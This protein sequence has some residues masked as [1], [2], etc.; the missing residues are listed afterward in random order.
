MY[1]AFLAMPPLATCRNVDV[2][3]ILQLETKLPHSNSQGRV[4]LSQDLIRVSQYILC[5]APVSCG[6]TSL[7]HGYSFP[8]TSAMETPFIG[9]PHLQVANHPDQIYQLMHYVSECDHLINAMFATA[10]SWPPKPSMAPVGERLLQEAKDLHRSLYGHL[11]LTTGRQSTY[12]HGCEQIISCWVRLRQIKRLIDRLFYPGAADAD[13]GPHQLEV[14]PRLRRYPTPI[15]V[16]VNYE[17]ARARLH[18]PKETSLPPKETTSW[19]L[20]ALRLGWK[21][22][23]ESKSRWQLRDDHFRRSAAPTPSPRFSPR[24]PVGR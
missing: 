6:R 4:G 22:I 23:A 15:H 5:S 2:L 14:G 12:D 8:Q 20:R 10:N 17:I 3:P 21:K 9:P 1:L 13:I 7:H 16:K 18:P 19:L 24:W 11:S